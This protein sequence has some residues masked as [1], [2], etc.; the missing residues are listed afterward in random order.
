ML[1]GRIKGPKKH[2]FLRRLFTKASRETGES[3]IGDCLQT[4]KE[5]GEIAGSLPLYIARGNHLLWRED[6]PMGSAVEKP[7]THDR[8]TVIDTG[9]DLQVPA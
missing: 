5:E 6:K 2:R 7:C 3:H 9:R 4:D 8:P 1:S